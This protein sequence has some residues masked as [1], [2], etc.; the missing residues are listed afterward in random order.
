M[1]PL[2]A[3]L[4]LD[5]APAHRRPDPL[6]LVLASLCALAGSLAGDALLVA[7][8]TAVFPATYGKLTVIGVLIACA[9]WPVTTRISSDPRWLFLRLAVLVTLVLLLPDVYILEQGQSAQAVAVLM[10]MHVVIGVVTYEALV[11]LAPVRAARRSAAS[12]LGSA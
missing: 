4:R 8:G 1:N 10:V 12:M 5:S 9:A 7:V 6:R 2:A 3:L 11:R